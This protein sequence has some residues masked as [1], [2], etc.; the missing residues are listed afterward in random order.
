MTETK[1]LSPGEI[2]GM[3]DLRRL[4]NPRDPPSWLTPDFIVSCMMNPTTQRGWSPRAGDWYYCSRMGVVR[5]VESLPKLISQHNS[6][7]DDCQPGSLL[8]DGCDLYLPDPEILE[9][10]KTRYY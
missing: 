7:G 10:M 2:R 1:I 6:L 9:K 8:S 3:R 4:G 5:K